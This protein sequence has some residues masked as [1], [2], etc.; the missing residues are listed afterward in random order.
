ME[1]QTLDA[2]GLKCPQPILKLGLLARTAPPG[3]RV[4]VLADCSAFPDDVRKWCTRMG[5]TLLGLTQS[6]NGYRAEVQL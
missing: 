2:R 1:T 4:T 5:K 3:T 6:G